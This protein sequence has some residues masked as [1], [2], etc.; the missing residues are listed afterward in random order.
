MGSIGGYIF[1]TTFGAFLLVLGSLTAITWVTQ[2]LRS[3]DLITNQGQTVLVFLGITGLLIPF[4]VLLIAPVAL[5]LAVAHV[6]NKLGTD[7]EIIVING[8]G[9]RPWQLFQ[10]FLAVTIVTALLMAAISAYIAPEGL[11]MLRRWVTEVRTDLVTNIVQP[12]RFVSLERGL[13]FHLRER[14]PNGLLL[15]IMVDDQRDEKERLTILAER[16]AILTNDRGNFLILENGSIQRHDLKQRDPNIVL[17]DRYAF[18]LSQFTSGPRNIRFSVRELYLWELIRPNP[19]DPQFKAQPGQFHAEFHDRIVAPLYPFAFVVIAYAFLG[20]PRT[21]RQSRVWSIVA[22]IVSVTTLRLIG[23]VSTVFAVNHPSAVL[24][25]YAAL[26]ATLAAGGYA[27]SRGL[28]IE[29]PAVLS[30]IVTA[31][32]NWLAPRAAATA[33]PTQ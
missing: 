8:A 10:P 11:R 19:E 7:F 2:A 15:G 25:P 3:I 14:R 5:L 23:F 29:P 16:G 21:T 13:A 24:F 22:V 17:F 32:M 30:S 6:L 28:I 31:C 26:A 4:L 18:D 1:R 20:A 27:I 33:R 9:M 12:G